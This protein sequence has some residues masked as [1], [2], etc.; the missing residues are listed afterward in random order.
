[1]LLRIHLFYKDWTP[2]LIDHYFYPGN[3][4]QMHGTP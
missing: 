4:Q 2:F 1:L 3:E